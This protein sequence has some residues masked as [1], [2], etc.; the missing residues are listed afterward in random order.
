M[1]KTLLILSMVAGFAQLTNAQVARQRNIVHKTIN[2]PAIVLP[3][4]YKTY[5]IKN[6][7]D[8]ENPDITSYIIEKLNNE[9]RFSN[10]KR[11]DSNSKSHVD[12]YVGFKDGAEKNLDF[13]LVKGSEI[14]F[15]T[16]KSNNVAQFAIN[17]SIGVISKYEVEL[18]VATQPVKCKANDFFY[19]GKIERQ[20][21]EENF[22]VSNHYIDKSNSGLYVELEIPTKDLLDY[23]EYNSDKTKFWINPSYRERI[24]E[25]QANYI[26]PVIESILTS[27]YELGIVK[28]GHTY[29][30][31]KDIPEE[32]EFNK[33]LKEDVVNAFDAYNTPGDLSKVKENLLPIME[34][35]K[36]YTQKYNKTDDKQVKIVWAALMDLGQIYQNTN[37]F[38]LAVESFKEASLTG[39]RELYANMEVKETYR[40]KKNYELSFDEAGN[41]KE[42]VP[43]TYI[44]RYGDEG[45][46]AIENVG[47]TI[48]AKKGVLYDKDD[49]YEG[50]ISITNSKKAEVTYEQKGKTKTKDFKAKDLVSICYEDGVCYDGFDIKTSFLADMINGDTSAT[51]KLPG[52][53]LIMGASERFY[54]RLYENEKV[55]INVDD[56]D[57]NNGY[58]IRLKKDEYGYALTKETG[59]KFFRKA[60][61]VFDKCN[62]LEKAIERGEYQNT[63]EDLQKM[64][65]V[66]NTC[67]KK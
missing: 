36:G 44:K 25:K 16:I 60:S 30:T 12:V 54:K 46:S 34:K 9:L 5:A 8:S 26:L 56:S 32:E 13:R 3:A 53:G 4:T 19:D 47:I 64:A 33:L 51:P 23:I 43:I 10:L 31:G 42:I 62:D 52:M 37:Q 58:L 24:L 6:F 57:P 67:V 48:E 15:L 21:L 63:I 35:L 2:Y 61:K 22:F 18:P 49:K 66:Y 20:E 1:K 65:D 14:S 41:K 45:S 28:E 40:R 17:D 55:T 39:F 27:D 7:T 38:D 11:V 29:Y 50:M 59:D